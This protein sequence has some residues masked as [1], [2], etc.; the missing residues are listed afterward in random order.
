MIKIIGL[1]FGGG[2]PP[3]IS[4]AWLQPA[5]KTDTASTNANTPKR[6]C[7]LMEFPIL[8]SFARLAGSD[9]YYL[10]GVLFGCEPASPCAIVKES[11]ERT[12]VALIFTR[13]AVERE[14][15]RIAAGLLS[16]SCA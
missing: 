15:H 7:R 9:G 5:R 12:A 3:F 6:L 2:G 10:E 13:S 4:I 16:V 11:T 14:M 8:C 1:V